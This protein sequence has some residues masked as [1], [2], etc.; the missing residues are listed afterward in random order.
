MPWDTN[1]F[2][3]YGETP[4]YGEAPNEIDYADPDYYRQNGQPALYSKQRVQSLKPPVES[5][6]DY[7]NGP[8]LVN[9][10]GPG[11]MGEYRGPSS[12]EGYSIDAGAEQREAAERGKA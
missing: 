8:T 3:E 9:D 12:L 2:Q 4:Q 1:D 11:M 6:A 10:Q 5:Y 7:E